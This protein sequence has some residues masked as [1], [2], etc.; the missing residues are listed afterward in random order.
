MSGLYTV[1]KNSLMAAKAGFGVP[2]DPKY[3]MPP[4]A[5][6]DKRGFSW[7]F[8]LGSGNLGIHP[9]GNIPGT[10]G[11]IGIIK[12]NTKPLFDKIKLL[13]SSTPITILVKPSF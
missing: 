9:D 8:W 2:Y 11:C 7:F 10:E 3:A 13:N 1:P 12:D 5:F 6:R 4:Y